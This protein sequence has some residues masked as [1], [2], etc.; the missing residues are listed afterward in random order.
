MK[1][2]ILFFLIV[3]CFEGV[4]HLGAKNQADF[5]IPGIEVQADRFIHI[6]LQ[7]KS[8]FN[9]P[10]SAELKEKIFLVI[11]I[12]NIKRAEYKIKYIDPKLFKPN[13]VTLFRTNFRMQKDLNL[14]V[15]INPLKVIPESDFSNNVRVKQFT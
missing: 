9:C 8:T 7:N 5:I 12:N 10:I 13:G 15:E 4:N 14:K 3:L 2:N 1:R 6:K 11:Y